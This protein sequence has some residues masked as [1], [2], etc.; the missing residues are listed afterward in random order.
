MTKPRSI[1][2]TQIAQITNLAESL[3]NQLQDMSLHAP[4]DVVWRAVLLNHASVKSAMEFAVKTEIATNFINKH[5]LPAGEQIQYEFVNKAI[6]LLTEW[7]NS[8]TK[9][10]TL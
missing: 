10:I 3:Y 5:Y 6:T 1:T 8:L 7:A 4:T 9:D 2:K